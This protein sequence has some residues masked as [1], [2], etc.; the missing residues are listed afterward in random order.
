MKTFLSFVSKVEEAEQNRGIFP[1]SVPRSSDLCLLSYSPCLLFP[2][3]AMSLTDAVL[4]CSKRN[5]PSATWHSF[6]DSASL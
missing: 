6:F 1:P 2:A 3:A 5:V 4:L